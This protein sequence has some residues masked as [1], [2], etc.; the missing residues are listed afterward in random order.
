MLRLTLFALLFVTFTGHVLA[1]QNVNPNI[2]RNYQNPDVSNWMSI[3]EQDGRE[4]FNRRYDILTAMQVEPGMSVADVGAGTGFFSLMLARAVGPNGKVYAVDISPEFL[5][6]IAQRARERGLN[7]VVTVLSD[8]K[9]VKLPL[10]QLDRI[11]IGDTYHH[12]EYPVTYSKTIAG[13]LKPAGQV[14]VVDFKRIPGWSSPW[15]LNHVRAGKEVFI[16]EM[17]EAG[18]VLIEELDFMRSQYFLRLGL[19]TS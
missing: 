16:S 9:D 13:A 8:Q 3:F 14:I 11:Y 19:P 17:N 2:N 6:A 7:N 10:A 1:E 4:I 15:V 5:D 12:F 18:L